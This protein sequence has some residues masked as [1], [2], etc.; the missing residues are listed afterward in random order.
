MPAISF[1]GLA[2]GIDSDALIKA[3]LDAQRLAFRPMQA[4]ID[5]G[6][7]ETKSLQG[8]NTKLLSLNDSLKDFLSLAGNGISKIGITSDKDLV[9]VSVADSAPASSTTIS[10]Q[11]LAKGATFSFND[12]F[13]SL[14]APIAPGIAGTETMTFTVGTGASAQTVT[15]DITNTTTL[16]ELAATLAQAGDGIL[17]ATPV[18]LGTDAVPQYGLVMAS[19]ETGVEKGT[20]AVSV[21]G[22]LTGAGLFGASTIDQAQDSLFTLAGIGQ[23]SRS[24]NKIS[25][26]IPGVTFDL[27]QAANIPVQITVN[28]DNDKTTE[29]FAK[30]VSLIN[31]LTTYSKENSQ[32]TRDEEKANTNVYGDLAKVRLDDQAVRD[33]KAALSDAISSSGGA[34][35]SF[36]DLGLSTN[37]DGTLTLDQ[38]KFKTAIGQDPKGAGDLLNNFADK[39]G[40]TGGIIDGY[41]RYQGTIQSAIKANEDQA[42]SLQDR[43][44]TIEA[45][46]GRQ[47]QMLKQLYANLEKKVGQ[48]Q[49]SASALTTLSSQ[50]YNDSK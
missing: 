16:Q 4:N 26:V 6:K 15:V 47:E 25:G 37:R 21:S 29:R 5:D 40:A 50:L 36:A 39:L 30:V 9:G 7:R 1:S 42:K 41:T 14:T 32:I 8:F 33:I 27:K 18:N 43:I 3:T 12:R 49:S 45:N 13:A 22:G 35:R 48:L 24:S 28:N 34:A 23:I 19:A 10:V 11:Q 31:E 17:T 46:L 44:D 20:L 2:S 38:E